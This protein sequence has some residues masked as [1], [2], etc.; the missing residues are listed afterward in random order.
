MAPPMPP[1][2]YQFAERYAAAEL[3]SIPEGQSFVLLAPTSS[4]E[5]LKSI[6][7]FKVKR[8]L[9]CLLGT[10][11]TA[12]VIRSGSLLIHVRSRDQAYLAL[13]ITVFMGVEVKATT[14]DKLN[15]TPGSV[16]APS[17][18]NLSEEELL[19]ELRPQGITSVV[20]MKSG[21]S[22]ANPRL[23]LYFLGLTLPPAIYAGYEIL[24]VRPWEV[25]PRLCRQCGR[26]GHLEA[27]CRS[28]DRNCLK[29]SSAGHTADECQRDEVTLPSIALPY[30]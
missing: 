25:N 28:K 16:Y 1:L 20:R 9:D 29:Y 2:S 4:R 5:T 18:A 11:A 17:L 3:D 7:P 10:V 24:E 27:T 26:F 14:T 22:R 15:S 19:R 23:K 30:D 6:S 13:D 12:K 21:N 8:E